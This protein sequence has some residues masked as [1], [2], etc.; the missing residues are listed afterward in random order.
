MGV[1]KIKGTEFMERFGHSLANNSRD[2]I[3]PLHIPGSESEYKEGM[4][5]LL[6]P[7]FYVQGETIQAIC[8]AL[9]KEDKKTIFIIGEQ[10]VGKTEIACGVV[11][12]AHKPMRVLVLAPPHLIKKWGE[13]IAATI[14][15]AKVIDISGK[16][17]LKSLQALSGKRKEKPAVHEFYI[18][19]KERAKGHYSVMPAFNYKLD[20]NIIGNRDV[21][22]PKCGQPQIK[23]KSNG[24]SYYLSESD[25]LSPS[26][27]I[28]P[29]KGARVEAAAEGDEEFVKRI[30]PIPCGEP[31]YTPV[32]PES[33]Y[34]YCFT[35]SDKKEIK[36]KIAGVRRYSP[37]IYAMKKLKNFW[38]LLIADELHEYKGDSLQGEAFGR[39]A[40]VCKKTI[41][42]TG[43]L[44]GGYSSDIFYLFYRTIP[45]EMRNAGFLYNDLKEWVKTYGVVDIFEKEVE[46]KV[47]KHTKQKPGISPLIFSKFLMDK[48]IFI[49]LGDLAEGLPPYCE[50]V[51]LM[52]M[53]SDQSEEYDS[54]VADFNKAIHSI[55]DIKIR[56]E[57]VSKYIH[58]SLSW[59]DRSYLQESFIT[60]KVDD[61]GKEEVKEHC[62]AKALPGVF[63]KEEELISIV[64]QELLEGRKVLVYCHYTETRNSTDRL[65]LLLDGEGF[66][67]EIMKS[68]SV[69]AKDRMKWIED[70][71]AQGLDV[72]ITNPELVKTGL[73]LLEFPTIVFYQQ[74]YN[75]FT[76]RQ[77]SR[78]SYRIGQTQPV[79][80]IFLAYRKTL[81]EYALSLIA[82]KIETALIAEGDISDSGLYD[83]S[84]AS[85]SVIRDLAKAVASGSVEG[86]ES[87][88]TV[89]GRARKKE[90]GTS[91]NL[92]DSVK[93]VDVLPLAAV[94]PSKGIIVDVFETGKPRKKK[95][96]R[97]IVDDLN[98]IQGVG[99]ISMF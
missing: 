69:S 12:A 92:S 48:A 59:L 87:A 74:S 88:A 7:P 1:Q 42:L 99:Q 41:C 13:E 3:Q 81:Q 89:W 70:K 44:T 51:R 57:F 61:N 54:M 76:V 21:S 82:A 83:V 18:M 62:R 84:F 73:D 71:T 11:N 26:K 29:K 10:G 36:G 94:K 38:D 40:A 65:K 19:S 6:R 30:K 98:K 60:R 91:L 55:S 14:P 27:C 16:D 93:K 34:E 2:I 33:P 64:R 66:K 35:G 45:R 37:A 96:V 56:M 52:D 20:M 32:L 97:M 53:R 63:P 46:G 50:E 9:Y 49:K 31:L 17:C 8:K 80:I 78:R 95:V 58:T 25:L 28:A 39:L 72:L 77:A 79:K 15:N 68:S 22:C 85:D 24:N 5:S 67:T 23:I 47:K 4:S 75:I 90:M 43:T 86:I